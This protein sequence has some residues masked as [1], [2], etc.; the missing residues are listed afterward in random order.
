MPSAIYQSHPTLN[1]RFCYSPTLCC[2]KL[3]TGKHGALNALM[4]KESLFLSTNASCSSTLYTVC[5][6]VALLLQPARL[7]PVEGVMQPCVQ[8]RMMNPVSSPRLGQVLLV[9]SRGQCRSAAP[10]E[11]GLTLHQL[12]APP[13]SA[14]TQLNPFA[15]RAELKHL[16]PCS[17]N[18]LSKQGGF[19]SHEGCCI[20]LSPCQQNH[21][22]CLPMPQEKKEKEYP[23]CILF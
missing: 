16:F 7:L 19:V 15:T 9:E 13:G 12:P 4:G 10:W 17:L 5:L 21:Y 2:H 20:P 23:L 6:W 11:G 14:T 3:C 8:G 18:P 1:W 22:Y